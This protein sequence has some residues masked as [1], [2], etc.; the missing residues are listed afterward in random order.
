MATDLTGLKATVKI[1]VDATAK[2]AVDLSVPEG[3]LKMAKSLALTFGTGAAKANQIFWDRRA[4]AGAGNDPLDLAGV[5]TNPFGAVITFAKVRAIIIFNRSDESLSHAGGSHTAT[6]AAIVVLDTG[7]T[8]TG[9]CKTLAKGM[10]VPAGGMIAVT[11]TLAAGWPVT[12]DTG[13]IL[14]VD[15]EDG[16]DEALYDI[17]I[18]GEAA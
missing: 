13:D 14:Q 17:A 16:S 18:I 6:D 5:L 8:F 11:T 15:N 1:D 7:S 3:I 9:P 2:K 4:I 12:V 10:V